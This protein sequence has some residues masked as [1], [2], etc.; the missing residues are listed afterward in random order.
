MFNIIEVNSAES[1]KRGREKIN[2]KKYYEKNIEE[3]DYSQNDIEWDEMNANY[4]WDERKREDEK[5]WKFNKSSISSMRNYLNA[6]DSLRAFCC[7]CLVIYIH[8]S[9][10]PLYFHIL[11]SN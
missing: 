7:C 6:L 2:K 10:K 1:V 4:D 11:S 8:K 5:R 3:K 9:L